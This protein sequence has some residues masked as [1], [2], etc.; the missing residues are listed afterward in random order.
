ME[1]TFMRID[2][3]D[4]SPAAIAEFLK[5]SA[6]GSVFVKGSSSEDTKLAEWTRK[7]QKAD[8]VL[9]VTGK[10]PFLLISDS[11]YDKGSE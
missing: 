8:A 3:G 2:K 7:D 5:S 9:G 4:L 10:T 1:L 6:E 11:E